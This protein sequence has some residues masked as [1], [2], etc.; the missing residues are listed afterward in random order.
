MRQLPS[1]VILERRDG[2]F[3]RS[4]PPG[5]QV[6]AVIL[7]PNCVWLWLL[8]YWRRDNLHDLSVWNVLRVVNN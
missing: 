1:R 7:L 5:I 2:D 8:L 6:P 4:V 3:V